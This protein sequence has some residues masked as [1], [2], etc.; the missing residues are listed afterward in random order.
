MAI[1]DITDDKKMGLTQRQV[2]VKYSI[3]KQCSTE[4]LQNTKIVMQQRR[5]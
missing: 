1:L 4:K 2:F 5:D 3:E